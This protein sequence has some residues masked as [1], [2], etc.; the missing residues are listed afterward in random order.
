VGA[1]KFPSAGKSLSRLSE[2]AAE[3]YRR[4]QG[5]IDRAIIMSALLL[6]VV[7]VLAL[8]VQAGAGTTLAILAFG[9]CIGFGAA[10]ILALIIAARELRRR[11][12]K[13]KD[14]EA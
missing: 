10:L 4:D 11:D 12:K 5:L 9:A 14:G 7:A 6:M 2:R 3:C 8:L 13:R 1:V